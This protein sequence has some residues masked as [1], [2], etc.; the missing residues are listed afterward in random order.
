M[1]G[2][3]DAIGLLEQGLAYAEGKFNRCVMSVRF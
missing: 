2:L 3:A 1:G